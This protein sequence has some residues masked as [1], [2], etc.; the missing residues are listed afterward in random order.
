MRDSDQ[1]TIDHARPGMLHAVPAEP[2]TPQMAKASIDDLVADAHRYRGSR[3]YGNLLRFMGRFRRYAP[4]NALM[5][6]SQM[7][8]AAFVAPANRWRDGYGRRVRPGERPIVV[9]QPFGPV[10]FVF[11]VSQT[12]AEPG[13][14]SL[15][16]GFVNPF[17]MPP[18]QSAERALDWA[19][20]NAKADGV[21]VS[22]VSAGSFVAGCIS[23]ARPGPVQKVA[24]SRRPPEHREVPVR[25]ETRINRSFTVTERYATLAHELAHLYCGH[26][27]SDKADRWPDRR[28][29]EDIGEFEA[30]SAAFIACQRLDDDARM[31]PHLAQYLDACAEVPFGISLERIAAAAGQIVEMSARWQKPHKGT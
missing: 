27:G 31:P 15:P 2:I 12:E 26:L 6:H 21:R 1:L 22:M 18:I 11:D 8:G 5:I 30:E 23:K 3:E 7:E 19:V 14:P 17:A 4:F 13:A 10:L 25:Y 9:L 28:V 29:A 24:V 20:E 16:E